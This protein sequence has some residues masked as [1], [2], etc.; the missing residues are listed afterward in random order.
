MLKNGTIIFNK[1][2][3]IKQIGVGGMSI[4]YLASEIRTGEKWAVKV[5]DKQSKEFKAM[6]NEQGKLT[7]CD[8][9]E[10]EKYGLA[11]GDNVIADIAVPCGECLL[12]KTG[13]DANCVN[14]GV[15]NGGSIEEAPY[16]WGGYTEEKPEHMTHL[17]GITLAPKTHPRIVF[18]GKLDSLE[19]RLIAC[20]LEAPEFD[21]ELGEILAYTRKLLRCEVLGE[22]V[23]EGT[24]C[25]MTE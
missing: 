20:R 22:P 24:L 11:M 9:A 25:G 15:T 5:I 16:L 10:A 1:Y 6:A 2:Q 4:V 13:D 17:D 23:E 14:M 18:R 7:D 8:P 12:C 19:A 21:Q 3:I